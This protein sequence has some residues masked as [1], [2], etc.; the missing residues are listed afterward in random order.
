MKNYFAF[1]LLCG[2]DSEWTMT[3]HIV[4]KMECNSGDLKTEMDQYTAND[5]ESDFRN[6]VHELFIIYYDS[7]HSVLFF[8]IINEDD[9]QKME[10]ER[11]DIGFY[12]YESVFLLYNL[13]E[14]LF[15]KTP[16]SSA[17]L[18]EIKYVMEE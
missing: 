13:K 1:G 17:V 14:L 12:H 15:I 3:L 6:R 18:E 5:T 8:V 2:P 16:N 9:F 4:K 11:K 7:N 10:N